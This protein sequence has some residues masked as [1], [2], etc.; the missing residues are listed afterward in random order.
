MVPACPGQGTL[1]IQKRNSESPLYNHDNSKEL[2]NPGFCNIIG[3]DKKCLR[4]Q[5]KSKNKMKI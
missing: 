2:Y 1:K 3:K 5:Q 4:K